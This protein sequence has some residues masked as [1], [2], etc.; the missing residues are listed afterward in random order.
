MVTE[1]GDG[2]RWW[3][4]QVVPSGRDDGARWWRQ[5]MVG[6]GARWLDEQVVP[7]GGGIGWSAMVRSLDGQMVPSGGDDGARWWDGQLDPRIDSSA[8]WCQGLMVV[9]DCGAGGIDGHWSRTDGARWLMM[10]PGGVTGGAR[11]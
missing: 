11:G 5:Q 3:D 4:G 7:S 1:D 10:L 2:A 9:P 6:D 8:R